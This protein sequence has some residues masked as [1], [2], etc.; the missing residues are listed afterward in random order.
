MSKQKKLTPNTDQTPDELMEK[1]TKQHL[2]EKE[3]AP[4]NPRTIKQI[5]EVNPRNEGEDD[6]AYLDR[7]FG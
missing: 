7:I 2:D 6:V 1:L 4:G 3:L 5:E